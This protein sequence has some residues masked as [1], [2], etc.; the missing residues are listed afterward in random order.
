M[1]KI[2][3]SIPAMIRND[4][5][6]YEGDLIPYFRAVFN[7]ARNLQA[8]YHNFRHLMHVT[9]LCYQAC[10]FY[11]RSISKRKQRNLLV[12]SLFHDFDHTGI[13]LDDTVNIQRAKEGLR[14]FILPT[15]VPF[16]GTIESLIDITRFPYTIPSDT[17][18][19]I[20]H[21]LRDVDMSQALDVVWIQ[22]VVIGLA[23][24]WGKKPIEILRTQPA[25]L[26]NLKF[27]T[28][29]A[30]KMFPEKAIAK[31]IEEAQQLLELIEERQPV[32][33]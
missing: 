8:P 21:I 27:S 32:A 29:W 30:R 6:I 16:Q 33:A 3:G 2:T 14:R 4:G 9:W 20:A 23:A 7:H 18:G 5:D 25:F 19:I 28:I 22:Q 1:Q 26:K 24:E 15:D 12:A 17:L 13:L 11:G 31:K 10:I